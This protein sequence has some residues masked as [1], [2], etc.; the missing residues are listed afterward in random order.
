MEFLWTHLMDAVVAAF[1][2]S[3]FALIDSIITNI[4]FFEH[5]FLI[6]FVPASNP[7]S[8]PILLYISPANQ[9]KSRTQYLLYGFFVI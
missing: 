8:I 5:L 2:N 6:G 9:T 3:R 1:S 7:Y 4:F